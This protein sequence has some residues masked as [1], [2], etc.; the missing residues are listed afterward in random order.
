MEELL[1]AT[2]DLRRREA[3]AASTDD[4]PRPG[5]DD[6]GLLDFEIVGFAELEGLRAKAARADGL[7][8]ERDRAIA[9]A[10]QLRAAI[11]AFLDARERRELSAILLAMAEI[12]R[13][14]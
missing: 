7:E 5:C 6:T 10:A 12:A 1:T 4:L 8:L 11:V 2:A 13:L 14:R 3:E 9:E